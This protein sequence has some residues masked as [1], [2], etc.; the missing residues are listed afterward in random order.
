MKSV[1]APVKKTVPAKEPKTTLAVKKVRRWDEDTTLEFIKEVFPGD[2]R[3]RSLSALADKMTKKHITKLLKNKKFTSKCSPENKALLGVM[4]DEATAWKTNKEA[5]EKAAQERAKAE[6]T[7]S[8]DTEKQEE[9]ARILDG[10]AK[11][12]DLAVGS[13]TSVLIKKYRFIV[14]QR[15]VGLYKNAMRIITQIP[16]YA[17]RAIANLSDPSLDAKTIADA[18]AQAHTA[19]NVRELTDNDYIE[20]K[21]SNKIDDLE[22]RAPFDNVGDFSEDAED[23]LGD[24]L[25]ESGDSDASSVDSEDDDDDN[26]ATAT[27]SAK[28]SGHVHRVHAAPEYKGLEQLGDD[29]PAPPVQP[30]PT[31]AKKAEKKERRTIQSIGLIRTVA[32]DRAF[33]IGDAA[34]GIAQFTQ[35]L[36]N[37]KRRAAVCGVMFGAVDTTGSFSVRDGSNTLQSGMTPLPFAKNQNL[38]NKFGANLASVTGMELSTHVPVKQLFGTKAYAYLKANAAFASVSPIA[39]YRR[40]ADSS[41][42]YGFAVFAIPVA[43]GGNTCRIVTVPFGLMALTDK[44]IGILSNGQYAGEAVKQNSVFEFI[45]QSMVANGV[46][47][48][49]KVFGVSVVENS[50]LQ[51]N[52]SSQDQEE[53]IKTPDGYIVPLPVVDRR[54][55]FMDFRESLKLP[56]QLNDVDLVD[57]EKTEFDKFAGS[58]AYVDHTNK[59]A[60][61]YS[62]SGRLMKA[63]FKGAAPLNV[64]D[65]ANMMKVTPFA[66][67]MDDDFDVTNKEHRATMSKYG[68]TTFIP[69]SYF[70][71]DWFYEIRDSSTPLHAVYVKGARCIRVDAETLRTSYNTDKV[72][73][74]RIDFIVDA[75]LSNKHDA[76]MDTLPP[77]IR[78][79][80]D[81]DHGEAY[82][83]FKKGYDGCLSDLSGASALGG[84]NRSKLSGRDISALKIL[85]MIAKKSKYE[86][87]ELADL[88]AKAEDSYVKPPQKGDL[89]NIVGAY[90]GLAPLQRGEYPTAMPHQAYILNTAQK[91]RS[92]ALDCDMGGGKTFM[93]T[94]DATHWIKTGVDG[95]AARP[96]VV[97]P[98]SLVT[99]YM[100]DV[101]NN[102]FGNNINFFV[103]S[104]STKSWSKMD[105]N[106][107]VEI[108]RKCPVNT[109]FIAT[110]EWLGLDSYDVVVGTEEKFR[111]V[112]I[113]GKKVKVP[114]TVPSMAPV[115]PHAQ[116]LLDIGINVIYLDESQKIKNPS[117][118]THKAVQALS[119]IPVK[120]IMTGTMVTR[121]VDDVFS[122]TSFID[123]T[124]IGTR[125]E[126]QRVFCGDDDTQKG[127]KKRK[128][129]GGSTEIT[130]GKEKQAK[131]LL[132]A[133]GVMNVRRS[134]W[135]GLLPKKTE[136]IEFV[137]LDPMHQLIY[138]VLVSDVM[139]G[140]IGECQDML[141]TMMAEA[142]ASGDKR[143]IEMIEKL[144][145]DLKKVI[146]I[147]LSD[148]DDLADEDSEFGEA[149]REANKRRL[150]EADDED[151]SDEDENGPVKEEA[152][153][154]LGGKRRSKHDN[155][156]QDFA[157]KKRSAATK[158]AM[159]QAFISAPEVLKPES[160]SDKAWAEIHRRQGTNMPEVTAKDNKI[161]ELIDKHFAVTGG[162]YKKMSEQMENA[163]EVRAGKVVIFAIN[164]ATVEHVYKF[165]KKTK[166]AGQTVRFVKKDGDAM[167]NLDAF[168]DPENESAGI[169]VACEQS[170]IYGHNMQSANLMINMT[171]PWTTGDYDQ[172][173][174][175][176]YRNGQKLACHIINI[177][178]ASTYDCAKFA[179]FLIR[180]NSN[181]K[182]ISDYD[183]KYN[184]SAALGSISKEAAAGKM[185]TEEQFHN[186][187]YNDPVSKR[188]VTLDFLELHRSVYEHELRE[189]ETH[190]RVFAEAGYGDLT[191][192]RVEVF[193]GES[194]IDSLHRP[195]DDN[196]E[197]LAPGSL[198][199]SDMMYFNG[200][201]L[202]TAINRKKL[203]NDMKKDMQR[204]AAE[205]MGLLAEFEAMNNTPDRMLDKYRED[206]L[207]KVLAENPEYEKFLPEGKTK[208][209]YK[210]LG[211]ALRDGR[212]H[213]LNGQV[214]RGFAAEAGNDL[215]D[216]EVRAELT[217]FV[218]KVYNLIV[219][220][221]AGCVT[222]DENVETVTPRR[223][224][225]EVTLS[226]DEDKDA[227]FIRKNAKIISKVLA[228]KLQ[229]QETSETGTQT[230]KKNADAEKANKK[231]IEEADESDSDTDSE[232]LELESEDDDSESAPP[233][234]GTKKVTIPEPSKPRVKPIKHD[235]EEPALD[236][237]N[238]LL[239][240]VSEYIVFDEDEEASGKNSTRNDLIYVFA[241]VTGNNPKMLK[242]LQGM[243]FGGARTPMQF[244]RRKVWIYG[245][246]I[247]DVSQLT[248]LCQRIEQS[249]GYVAKE[250]VGRKEVYSI[251]NS[252]DM[253]A[254]L[255][256][257]APTA[258]V[259]L[260]EDE[261][262]LH[263]ARAAGKIRQE[264]ELGLAMLDRRITVMAVCK[265][266]AL[267]R[268]VGFRGIDV[269]RIT[270]PHDASLVKNLKKVL[271]GI[272]EVADIRNPEVLARRLKVI[273]KQAIDV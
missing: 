18:A 126:F 125:N 133:S 119:T 137:S 214:N 241:P 146:N 251:V 196:N 260:S 238:S 228:N 240:G 117:S 45:T 124:M 96:C 11:I 192:S 144:G 132:N 25:D 189:A 213:L 165:L 215:E 184:L 102:F 187:T 63:I 174:A 81:T 170:I 176:I 13:K 14:N 99:N 172:K 118:T 3:V 272:R 130:R 128:K 59:I 208:G 148:G 78:Q 138:N 94:L 67:G 157:E 212:S 253:N 135:I 80:G 268:D 8:G 79:H 53:I 153:P 87:P 60:Y 89:D 250:Q 27:A 145:N 140:D 270:L 37:G 48:R 10:L 245:K 235:T 183:N 239:L 17:S 231:A 90:D 42:I 134:M 249:G 12:K 200:D 50:M 179:K 22:F 266:E 199:M 248:R 107:I 178:A 2:F 164:I 95:A 98:A 31:D 76:N 19:F 233:T 43:N 267:L 209:F 188:E 93:S 162:K 152:I 84:S 203:A 182:L 265:N 32:A 225:Q 232:D 57:G 254:L 40:N 97:M 100:A 263:Q 168:K 169:I 204:R 256:I 29:V 211:G 69:E 16:A 252:P 269:A 151:E 75:C 70:Q 121:D 216:M 44:E 185:M 227:K 64:R 106:K 24:E 115:F 236:E 20:I 255:R 244:Q 56:E 230:A 143:M 237:S 39:L 52:T 167:K 173:V 163:P 271:K 114:V 1:S 88:Q 136:D 41:G 71:R 73:W 5:E 243:N 127:K 104:S 91:Q 166:Y 110:Y 197:Q 221:Y 217:V 131:K 116:A 6:R 258:F 198:E 109:M 34:Q 9:Q 180:Q 141:D 154:V 226:L 38:L 122:Q 194:T 21:G 51:P 229:I 206:A 242:R 66:T 207:A 158:L 186:F 150:S 171:I 58:I 139:N 246:P 7:R 72:L 30:K 112:E 83:L 220:N 35:G 155:L 47:T 222:L 33:V 224:T 74:N 49:G 54:H 36:F 23:A 120:R 234:R 142:Q 190:D 85:L 62:G 257:K 46:S 82:M 202:G 201:N 149:A 61:Y 15:Y 193:S 219:Q 205:E 108:A 77:G 147:V 262:S 101:K 218:R 181:R 175:R 113:N 210:F 195:V 129:K 261:G 161:L 68:A 259:K 55:E 4:D 273:T 65:M 123:G 26:E 191:S 103:L 223:R 156:F 159:I 264:V 105:A 92:M 86:W 177:V 247:T 160:F 111:K 28:K